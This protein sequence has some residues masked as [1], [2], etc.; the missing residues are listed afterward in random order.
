MTTINIL[1][2]VLLLLLAWGGYK[3][4]HK[5]FFTEFLSLL[6]FLVSTLLIFKLLQLGLTYYSAKWSRP[7]KALSFILFLLVVSLISFGLTIFGRKRMAADRFEVFD[8][9][10]NF[11]GLIFG[12]IKYAVALSVMLWVFTTAGLLRPVEDGLTGTVFYPKLL[13]LFEGTLFFLGRVIA[14]MNEMVTQ[15]KMLLR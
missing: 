11:M 14:P 1:D 5:G 7:P 10:D 3:G 9:F 6:I 8:N 4:F 2:V 15:I 13:K 12:V